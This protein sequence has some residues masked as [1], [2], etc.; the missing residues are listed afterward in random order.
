MPM[1]A[2]SRAISAA[3]PPKPTSPTVLPVSCMPSVRGQPPLRMAPSIIAVLRA[4][5]HIRA[6][7][8]SAT[9]VSP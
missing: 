6:K 8:I 2:Q 1:P 7:A 5:S 3:M 4:A 9:A